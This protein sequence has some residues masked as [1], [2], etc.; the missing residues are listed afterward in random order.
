MKKIV[1]TILVLI[2][3]L[4]MC[5]CETQKSANKTKSSENSVS[6]KIV[7]KE[8]CNLEQDVVKHDA[9]L[10]VN[11]KDITK[12][13]HIKAILKDDNPD[14]S[15][16][17]I[18]FLTIIKELGAEV[19]WKTQTKAEIY[20]GGNTY[21]LKADKVSFKEKGIEFDMFQHLGGYMGY[22]YFCLTEDDYILSDLRCHRALNEFGVYIN[23]DIKNLRV[24]VYPK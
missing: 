8:I 3:V 18:P 24:T 11:G 17:E 1:S 20:F 19:E 6:S 12:E 5:S 15:Y 10:I 16:F 9:K 2:C 22:P 21:I 13:V 23:S 14:H 4:L 7:P